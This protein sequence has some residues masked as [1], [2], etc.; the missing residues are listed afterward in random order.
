MKYGTATFN[1]HGLNL[2]CVLRPIT[3][4]PLIYFP[5]CCLF[6][7]HRCPLVAVT[8]TAVPAADVAGNGAASAR[9]SGVLGSMCLNVNS[10]SRTDLCDNQD[11]TKLYCLRPEASAS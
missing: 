6:L 11:A 1:M 7:L 3:I 9:D 8:A 10:V 2:P 5:H 4:T